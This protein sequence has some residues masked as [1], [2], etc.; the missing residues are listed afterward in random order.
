LVLDLSTFVTTVFGLVLE[1]LIT[2]TS[3][4]NKSGSTV[5]LVIFN[6]KSE[7]WDNW[8]FGFIARAVIYNYYSILS[9][10]E[11]SPTEA[12]FKALDKKSTDEAVKQKL[13]NFKAN[14]LAYSHLVSSM[15]MKGDSCRVAIG[16]LRNSRMT[17]LPVGDAFKAMNELRNYYNNK[18]VATIQSLLKDYNECSI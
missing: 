2:M 16:L 6:G 10:D 5:K 17:A 4:D 14:S 9:G 11:T 12:E 18:S 8:E 13:V 15:D 7:S 3:E 1:P